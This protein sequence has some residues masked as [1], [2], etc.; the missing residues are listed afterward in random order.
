M[1]YLKILYEIRKKLIEYTNSNNITFNSIDKQYKKSLKLTDN[2]KIYELDHNE[3]NA[4]YHGVTY[5][6][7]KDWISYKNGIKIADIDTLT[8]ESLGVF[9]KQNGEPIPIE[10]VIHVFLHELA[11]TITIPEQR[12]AKTLSKKTKLLQSH[13]A[14]KKKNKF[15]PCHHSD[16]FYK[17]FATILR[18]AE[19]L[20]IYILPKT[21]KNFSVRNLQ[22]YDC[23]FNPDDKLSVGESPLYKHLNNY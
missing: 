22:R 20:K 7:V 13:V 4:E 16:N 12:I 15:M 5:I 21:N 17:N 6:D 19:Q 1:S 23:M 18:I 8:I 14:E 9:F 11:H 2:Y 3:E 10:I